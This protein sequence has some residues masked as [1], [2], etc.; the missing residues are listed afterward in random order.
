MFHCFI[1]QWVNQIVSH[2]KYQTHKFWHGTH[3][4]AC[5]MWCALKTQQTHMS[6]WGAFNFATPHDFFQTKAL[7][8]APKM[9]KLSLITTPPDTESWHW[10]RYAMMGNNALQLCFLRLAHHLKATEMLFIGWG[11][12][13]FVLEMSTLNLFLETKKCCPVCSH[14]EN[15]EQL[16]PAGTSQKLH[17]SCHFSLG[18]FWNVLYDRQSP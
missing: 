13:E 5:Q 3:Q 4:I 10:A 2:F 14:D 15:Y 17:N 7:E 18:F 11:L 1:V 12:H 9:T 16:Q 8:N 6:F